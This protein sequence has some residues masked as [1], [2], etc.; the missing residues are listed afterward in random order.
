M[1]ATKS[2][3]QGLHLDQTELWINPVNPQHLALGNDGGFYVSYD[4]GESWMHYNNI[5]T[6]EFYDIAID[7]STNI[8]Y[9]IPGNTFGL[10]RGMV[11][12]DVLH[13]SIQKRII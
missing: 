3:A 2:K 5:P 7:P 6:G 12:M 10:T 8:I 1:H 11:A 9:Q 4:K 13:K